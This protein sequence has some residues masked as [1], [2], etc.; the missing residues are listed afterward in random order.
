MTSQPKKEVKLNLDILNAPSGA[1]KLTLE[2]SQI[3]VYG[4]AEQ[5]ALI[6]NNSIT[7]GTLDYRTLINRDYKLSY[8]VVL[9]SELS[10]CH[11]IM[12]EDDNVSAYLDLS[13]YSKTTI[14]ADIRAR[15]DTSKY[16]A[17]IVSAQTVKLTVF[18]PEDLI[19]EITDSDLSV[20]ADITKMTNQLDKEKTVS[21]TVP[22]TVTFNSGYTT[23]WAYQTDSVTVN[24]SPKK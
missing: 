18:G 2:P 9:P 8:P 21:I 4:P 17:E 5:L 20:V 3:S 24:V 6:K 23:C 16:T 10:E 19:S 11:A 12:E 15:V 13:S 22:L 7:I 14:T 1:P